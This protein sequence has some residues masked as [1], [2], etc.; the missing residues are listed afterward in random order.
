MAKKLTRLQKEYQKE[1]KRLTKGMSYWKKKG[2]FLNDMPFERSPKRVTQKL[3]KEIKQT[4]PKTLTKYAEQVDLETGEIISSPTTKSTPAKQK[5]IVPKQVETPAPAPATTPDIITT[6]EYI[7][8]LSIIDEI[9]A[10][11]NEMPD[12]NYSPQKSGK[13]IAKRRN[14]LLVIFEDVINS[15][16]DSDMPNYIDYLLNHQSELFSSLTSIEYESEDDKID[17]SFAHAGIILNY[18]HSL[19]PWQSELLDKMQEYQ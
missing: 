1:Y 16:D 3:L 17:N 14:N 11:I 4:K 7:P 8:N 18:G 5:T 2:Y 9:I 13:P 10:R 12:V 6:E 15:I 19:S